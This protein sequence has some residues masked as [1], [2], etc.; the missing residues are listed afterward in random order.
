MFPHN[1]EFFIREKEAERQAEIKQIELGRFVR[2]RPS[3]GRRRL[4]QVIYWLGSQL[5]A[6]ANKL[7]VQPVTVASSVSEQT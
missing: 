6:W 4:A 3:Q 2:Q 1:V 5:I 7:Q